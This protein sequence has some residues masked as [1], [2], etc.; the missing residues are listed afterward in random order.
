MPIDRL[1]V[2]TDS[3]Y[4][5]PEPIRWQTNFPKNVAYVA[6]KLAEIKGVSKD[7]IAAATAENTK[8]VFGIS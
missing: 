6:D 3:P 7:K 5:T 8:R 2:E 1:L 4:L